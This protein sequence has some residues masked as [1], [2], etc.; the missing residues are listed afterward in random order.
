MY[1]P[2]S[3][4]V[5][6]EV[7]QIIIAKILKNFVECLPNY[8][9]LFLSILRGFPI[10]FLNFAIPTKIFSQSRN[11]DG[12]FRS[13]PRPRQA[14][15]ERRR[16]EPLGES[17]GTP[18]RKFWSLEAQKWPFSQSNFFKGLF[19][20]LNVRPIGGIMVVCGL[21]FREWSSAIGGNMVTR[22]QD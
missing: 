3:R 22:E 1:I 10:G 6:A 14:S 13:I 12:L 7:T 5:T 17:G 21:I 16:C 18:P 15:F 20:S 8:F 11:P 2:F 4:V 19:S 9:V